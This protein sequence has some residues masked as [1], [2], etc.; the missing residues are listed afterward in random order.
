MDGLRQFLEES[1]IAHRVKLPTSIVLRRLSL[2]HSELE[3]IVESGAFAP[4]G[5]ETCEL[6]VGGQSVAR[7]RIVR[8]GGASY[9]KVLEMDDRG[10]P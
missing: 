1:P 9:F 7:G 5:G 8:R 2:S 10:Q 3:G 6:E 4:E